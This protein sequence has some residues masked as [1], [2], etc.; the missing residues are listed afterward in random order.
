MKEEGGV[1]SIMTCLIIG[2]HRFSD[3]ALIG[4]ITGGAPGVSGGMKANGAR[5]LYLIGVLFADDVGQIHDCSA[6]RRRNRAD[7]PV[8]KIT[9]SLCA[10]F[11]RY[12]TLF[13][14]RSGEKRVCIS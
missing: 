5:S 9:H 11:R 1:G 2:G 6:S 13:R 3:I 8:C 12:G 4:G 7:M 14:R 10:G